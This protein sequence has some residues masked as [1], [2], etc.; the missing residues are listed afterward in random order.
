MRW[1]S[2]ASKTQ[3][4]VEKL[5]EWRPHFLWWPTRIKKEVVWLEKVYRRGI[6]RGYDAS[7]LSARRSAMQNLGADNPGYTSRYRWPII[8]WEYRTDDLDM[9]KNPPENG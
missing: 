7:W 9:I 2:R 8:D 5:K 3:E 4:R 1:K 6:C